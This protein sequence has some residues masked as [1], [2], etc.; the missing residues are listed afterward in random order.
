MRERIQHRLQVEGRA[1]D[2]FEHVGGGGL[3][4]QRLGE[5]K[6]ARLKLLL[7]LAR[8]RLELLFRCRLKFLRPAEMTHAGHPQAEI[9]RSEHSTPGRLLC[10]TVHAAGRADEVIE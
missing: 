10:E 9:R 5:F 8:V 2:D 1:T 4:L 3:L 6:G 7:Q